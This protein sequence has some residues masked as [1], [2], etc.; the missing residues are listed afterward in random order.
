[1]DFELVLR[2]RVLP[3]VEMRLGAWRSVQDSNIPIYEYE[4]T[5]WWVSISHLFD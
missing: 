1:L 3:K 5:D 4:R 2:Y